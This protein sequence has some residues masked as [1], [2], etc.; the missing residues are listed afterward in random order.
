MVSLTTDSPQHKVTVI[1]PLWPSVSESV[2]RV[3]LGV[4]VFHILALPRVTLA[5]EVKV[6]NFKLFITEP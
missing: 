3:R 1:T 5:K 2:L 6:K 4:I